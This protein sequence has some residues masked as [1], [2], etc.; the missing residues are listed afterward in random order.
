M[1]NVWRSIEKGITGGPYVLWVMFIALCGLVLGIWFFVE[2]YES[3][4]QGIQLLEVVFALTSVNYPATYGFMSIAPQIGQVL[5]FALF[6]INI[7]KNWWA[8]I[9]A[10]AWFCL[11]FASD[12]QDRSNG[13]FIELTTSGVQ[14]INW[15]ARTIVS[16]VETFFFFT[17]G[18]ELFLT[19][20]VALLITLFPASVGEYV[21]MR[22]NIKK[23]LAK[24]AKTLKETD[25]D[26]SRQRKQGGRSMRFN[27]DGMGQPV[28]DTRQQTQRWNR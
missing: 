25:Q 2:D 3:S 4:R 14:A 1:Q 16:A 9:V 28:R 11:D 19:A 21:K 26:V 15:D 22:N 17:I 6:T 20:S 27:N 10:L 12:V 7:K 5:F 13:H 23:E 18:S 24:A 8:A